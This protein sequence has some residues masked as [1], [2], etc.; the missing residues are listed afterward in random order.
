LGEP[1]PAGARGDIVRISD[2]L[3]TI[4]LTPREYDGITESQLRY[5]LAGSRIRPSV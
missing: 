3:A 5:L 4:Y 1:A 2:G